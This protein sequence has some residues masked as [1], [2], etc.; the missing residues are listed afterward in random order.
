MPGHWH[1][2]P[3][4]ASPPFLGHFSVPPVVTAFT[5]WKACRLRIVPF[6]L[7]LLPRSR[8]A[9]SCFR[10]VGLFPPGWNG[11]FHSW[12]FWVS[13]SVVFSAGRFSPFQE[14]WVPDYL[15]SL[16]LAISSFLSL[17][18][19]RACSYRCRSCSSHPSSALF[20]SKTSPLWVL[21]VSSA[22]DSEQR[23]PLGRSSCSVSIFR[24]VSFYPSG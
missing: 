13:L 1:C 11:S 4:R 24:L 19:F 20:S 8:L 23:T 22:P 15:V 7:Y 12:R 6:L 3:C 5:L 21:T 9:E 16:T 10:S 14:P 2:R 18:T 17:V